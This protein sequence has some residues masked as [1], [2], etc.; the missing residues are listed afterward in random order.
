MSLRINDEAPLYSIV[1]TVGML[2]RRKIPG[3]VSCK[4]GLLYF[5]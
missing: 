3:H 1:R 2:R 5:P 4:V